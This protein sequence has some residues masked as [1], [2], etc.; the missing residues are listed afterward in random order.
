[1][2]SK[3]RPNILRS[4]RQYANFSA[5]MF[6]CC[7][8]NTL[9]QNIRPLASAIRS[10]CTLWCSHTI[11]L[12]FA[13]EFGARSLFTTMPLVHT[14][15]A[16][17]CKNTLPL[18]VKRILQCNCATTYICP[19]ESPGK[20]SRQVSRSFLTSNTHLSLHFKP[21]A[22]LVHILFA[23]SKQINCNPVF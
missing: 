17:C 10:F 11:T 6:Q 15:P 16:T 9:L 12:K 20:I 2:S 7:V 23:L 4:A 14:M 21:V 19:V 22:I 3:G 1:M 8:T 18:Q 13:R 5:S